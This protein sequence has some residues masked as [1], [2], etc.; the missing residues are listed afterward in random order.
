MPRLPFTTTLQQLPR[1]TRDTWFLL[2]VIAWTI[3]PHGE[4]LPL[5]C[6]A[7]AVALL[8]WRGHIAWHAQPLPSR[9]WLLGLLIAAVAATLLSY[10]SVFG[11]EPGVTLVVVLLAL[12]TLEMRARRDAF[13][14]FFLGFFTLLS[15]F[16]YS[17]SLPTAV[18]MLV[19]LLG[20]L[21]ALVNSQLP[22]GRPPLWQSARTALWMALLGAPIMALLFAF[23]PRIAPLWGLPTDAAGGRSGL[24]AQM[25][26]GAVSH[27]ALDGSVALRVQ[28]LGPRPRQRA[29]YFRGPVLTVF[30]GREWR[31][32]TAD[33]FTPA[34]PAALQVSG[35]A[36]AYR[37][38]LEPNNHPWLLTLDAT[39]DAPKIEGSRTRMQPDLQWV[40]D[41]P[42]SD[43]LRYEAVAYPEFRHGP[44]RAHPGLQDALALPP[45]LNPR[46]QALAQEIRRTTPSGGTPALVDAVLQRLRTGGYTYTLDPGEFGVHTADEFW[47]ERKAGFCEHIASSFVLLMRAMGVPARIVTGYQGGEVNSL[48]GFFTV[49]QSD[50]HAWA[51]VWHAEDGWV[52]V[53]PTSAV[54]PGRTGSFQP[55]QAPPGAITSVVVTVSPALAAQLRAFWDA[56]NNRWNQWVLNYSQARQLDLLRSLG[57]ASPSWEDLVYVLAGLV[58]A[59]GSLGALWSAW[60]RSRQDPWLRL[61]QRAQKRLHRYGL[62]VDASNGPRAMALWVQQQPW[63]SA[64]Q[65][66][67]VVGWLLR[68]ETQRYS[69]AAGAESLATLGAAWRR[70]EWPRPTTI[71]APTPG[72]P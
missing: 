35:T 59:A 54:A 19:S 37:V 53:D 47:F 23:F 39:P 2:L 14:I 15:N 56:T 12:K 60:E 66:Q 63:G 67:A 33:P 29:L 68:M 5:W 3:T 1:D 51:E 52:R 26:V 58:A 17:Q 50:A 57:V 45:G 64:P 18:A 40:L 44:A 25:K 70:L 24:S 36:Y 49:R 38:T 7:A 30:D 62:H 11:R 46:T 28:F 65:G 21:T 16:F 34:P 10:R 27:L 13:V 42:V 20:L 71:P 41:R 48:D 69:A 61:L 9:W 31:A 22:V 8:A 32:G 72:S 6:S 4:H 43:L 55:L